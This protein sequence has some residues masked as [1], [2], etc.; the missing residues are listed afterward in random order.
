MGRKPMWSKLN[1]LSLG[2]IK[3]DYETS[4]RNVNSEPALEKQE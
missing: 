4:V 2:E 3:K 1:L